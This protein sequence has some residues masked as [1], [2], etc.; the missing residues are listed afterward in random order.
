MVCKIFSLYTI[1]PCKLE[2]K[3][4]WSLQVRR[5]IAGKMPENR[6]RSEKKT[7]R[8]FD[9]ETRFLKLVFNP[10][11]PCIYRNLFYLMFFFYLLI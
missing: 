2:K 8:R 5:K 3:T 1:G 6:R 4:N 7:R 11:G 9:F 10:F